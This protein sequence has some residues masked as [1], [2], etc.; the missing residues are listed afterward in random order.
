QPH[1]PSM[2]A[3]HH[4]TRCWRA[5]LSLAAHSSESCESGSWPIPVP[6]GGCGERMAKRSNSGIVWLASYPR[7]GNTW[8]RNFLNN[9]FAVLEGRSDQPKDINLLNEYTI[10][11]IP[12]VRFERVIGKKMKDARRTEIAASRPVVQRQIAD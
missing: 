8:T 1:V 7:S 10:W 11:D 9:L 6:N 4:T 3:G 12:A 5:G 2:L